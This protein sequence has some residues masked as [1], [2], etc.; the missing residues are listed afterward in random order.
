MSESS[1][2]SLR[3]H[4]LRDSEIR[5]LK[6]ERWSRKIGIGN[7]TV[8][9]NGIMLKVKRCTWVLPIVW[10]TDFQEGGRWKALGFICKR[11]LENFE[12]FYKVIF[13][14]DSVEQ[15][16]V[17][18]FIVRPRIW[19]NDLKQELFLVVVF[20]VRFGVFLGVLPPKKIICTYFLFSRL[21]FKVLKLQIPKPSFPCA[22]KFSSNSHYSVYKSGTVQPSLSRGPLQLS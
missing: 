16:I 19:F 7:W 21:I 14:K 11:S 12:K 20:S 1:R 4:G 5:F 3:W 8:Q 10:Y 17:Q 13:C 15:N 6:G 9:K 2:K 22:P 18:W